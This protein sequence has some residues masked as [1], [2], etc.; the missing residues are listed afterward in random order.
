MFCVHIIG[1]LGNQMFQVAFAHVLAKKYNAHYFLKNE[2]SHKLL[3]HKYFK[4][5]NFC[6]LKNYF[7]N[8][9]INISKYSINK[10]DGDIHP[11]VI[12]KTLPKDVNKWLFSGYYQSDAFYQNNLKEINELFNIKLK[13][14]KKFYE[15]YK[16]LY[17]KNKIIAIHVR[18]TDYKE[19]NFNLPFSYYKNCLDAINYISEYKVIIISDDL[20]TA[21]KMFGEKENYLFEQNEQIIDFQIL[22]NADIVI[23]ANSSFS[24]WA[25]YLNCKKNKVIYAPENWLNYGGNNE[26]PIGIMNKQWEWINI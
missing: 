22:Q 2:G 13:Y 17:E 3:V 26:F 10:I 1:R 4:I 16:S 23:I 25:A 18:L 24:W 7:L 20:F 5:T 19:N 15:K 9:F 21:K 6:I 14:K 8:I 12:V 11:D